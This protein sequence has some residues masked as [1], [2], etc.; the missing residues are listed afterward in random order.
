MKTG[1]WKIELYEKEINAWRNNQLELS[2]SDNFH[3]KI[4]IDIGGEYLHNPYTLETIIPTGPKIRQNNCIITKK[5]Q[6]TINVEK[7]IFVPKMLSGA[8]FIS[9][10]QYK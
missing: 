7:T 2:N 5:D 10:I 9:M 8:F 1:T 6:Y 3:F 4:S